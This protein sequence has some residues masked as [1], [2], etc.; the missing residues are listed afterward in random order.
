MHRSCNNTF[1][2]P[3]QQSLVD[4]FKE[5]LPLLDFT[6]DEVRKLR[7]LFE[8]LRIM[9]RTLRASVKTSWKPTGKPV[10]DAGMTERLKSKSGY[11]D[12]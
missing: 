7:P 1:F 11:L 2:I 12:R 5:S 9:D 4:T 10:M 6:V 3:D 8:S